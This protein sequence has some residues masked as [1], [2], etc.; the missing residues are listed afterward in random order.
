ME[1]AIGESGPTAVEWIQYE[2]D[3]SIARIST[4][5]IYT[6]TGTVTGVDGFTYQDSVTV[7][8][9]DPV[10]IDSLLRA[11][12][13]GMTGSLSIEDAP[14]ALVYIHP[15]MRQTYQTIFSNLTGQLGPITS[16][17]SAFSFVRMQDAMAEYKLTT[18]EAGKIYSYEVIFHKDSTGIW[19]IQDF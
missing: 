11:K 12:W 18:L 9:Y 10:Y 8:A 17:Q 15:E 1:S 19:R 5:G 4:P 13:N 7:V 14:S 3:Q 16:T 2:V 6:F